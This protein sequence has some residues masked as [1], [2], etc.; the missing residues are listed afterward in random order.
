VETQQSIFC[1]NWH[2]R[3]D[4]RRNLSQWYSATNRF[5]T[6]PF[7]LRLWRI[8]TDCTTQKELAIHKIH[9]IHYNTPPENPNTSETTQTLLKSTQTKKSKQQLR[10]KDFLLQISSKDIRLQIL[11]D[12]M[13]SVLWWARQQQRAQSEPG[14]GNDYVLLAIARQKTTNLDTLFSLKE[15]RSTS[16]TDI[17]SI[18]GQPGLGEDHR[19]RSTQARC[20][21][22][23]NADLHRTVARQCGRINSKLLDDGTNPTSQDFFHLPPRT[24]WYNAAVRLV[25]I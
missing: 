7:T 13:N 23:S 4:G 8:V 21:P 14:S 24:S 19:H 12:L 18:A 20:D 25:Y 3:N 9:I 5:Q 2:S 17:S 10:K 1:H 16:K 22:R 6:Y 15:G 11:Q